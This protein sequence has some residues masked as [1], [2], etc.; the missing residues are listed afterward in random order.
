MQGVSGVLEQHQDPQEE[1]LKIKKHMAQFMA[2]AVTQ[3]TI[4]LHMAKR[5]AWV[6]YKASE[7]GKVF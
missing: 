3:V 7:D 2:K 1:D 6:I 4:K 5:L